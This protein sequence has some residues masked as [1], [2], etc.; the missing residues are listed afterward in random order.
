MTDEEYNRNYLYPAISLGVQ[1]VDITEEDINQLVGLPI[2][3]KDKTIG[4]ILEAKGKQL[5]SK[6]SIT[7]F[8][9]IYDKQYF[10]DVVQP[11]CDICCMVYK[12]PETGEHRTHR[13]ICYI[14]EI[15]SPTEIRFMD[16]TGWGKNKELEYLEP[17]KNDSMAFGCTQE[18][19]AEGAE[20]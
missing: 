1:G 9:V 6:D 2:V 5:L 7:L 8:G 19:V 12:D 18:H 14:H 4:K 11:D 17:K 20:K 10:R 16:G 3:Y 15:V 13:N